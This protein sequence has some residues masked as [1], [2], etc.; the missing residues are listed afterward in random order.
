MTKYF[1]NLRNLYHE[2]V[3]FATAIP[4]ADRVDI[5]IHLNQDVLYDDKRLSYA[6]YRAFIDD[7]RYVEKLPFGGE[8]KLPDLS[9]QK[10]DD[11]RQATLFDYI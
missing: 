4:R 2:G 9:I 10:E 6:E 11:E 5:F 8:S 3:K 7:N 1:L